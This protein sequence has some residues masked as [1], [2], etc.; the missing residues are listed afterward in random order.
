MPRVH[1][2]DIVWDDYD[3]EGVDLPDEVHVTLGLGYDPDYEPA[4]TLERIYGYT[5]TRFEVEF[6]A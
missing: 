2:Y 3:G 4:E 6:D 1:V 5:P